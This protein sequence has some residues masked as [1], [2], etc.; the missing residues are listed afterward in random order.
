MIRKIS[1]FEPLNDYNQGINLAEQLSK[2]TATI[3]IYKMGEKGSITFTAKEKIMTGIFPVSAL[4]P[5]GAGDAFMG[6]FISSL[7]KKRTLKESIVYASAAAAIVVTRVGCSPAMP[8]NEE[9]DNFVNNNK[10]I[11]FIDN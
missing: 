7:L 10:I 2:S 9:L 11:K 6:V 4:K 1:T 8:N 3:V 5:T